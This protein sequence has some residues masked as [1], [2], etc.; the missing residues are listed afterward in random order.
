M[1]MDKFAINQP[2]NK[3]SVL[4]AAYNEVTTIVPAVEALIPV[5]NSLKCEFEV[6]VVES[7]STDGTRELLQANIQNLGISLFL[8]ESPKGKGS[9]IR[10][11][12]ANMSG[13]VFL[14]YDADTEYLASDIPMLLGPIESGLTSFVLGTRHE[15]GR[16]M[17]V[18]DEHRFTPALMN[19]AHKFFTTLINLSFFVRLTDPFTMYKVF[20]S[21]VFKDVILVSNR[22]DFDWELVCKGIR[23]GCTPVEIPVFYKSRSFSEGK[24]VRFIRDPITWFVAL[25]RFRFGSVVRNSK[26]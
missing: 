14:I 3:L 10:L 7:N 6:I 20:R 1:R 4:V 24:K 5:L 15:K 8:E 13:D 19:I 9:A 22:F 21:D 26:P 16:A 11:A 2:I 18:M 23:L 12:M 25:I 17:R